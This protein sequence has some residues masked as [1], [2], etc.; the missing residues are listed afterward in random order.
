MYCVRLKGWW[1]TCS[2]RRR[3]RRRRRSRRRPCLRPLALL[4]S[5]L[6]VVF[7]GNAPSLALAARRRP[8]RRGD[9]LPFVPRGATVAGTRGDTLPRSSRRGVRGSSRA[10]RHGDS[11]ARRGRSVPGSRARRASGRRPRRP[12][13]GRH[14]AIAASGDSGDDA[15]AANG[16]RA[17]VVEVRRGYVRYQQIVSRSKNKDHTFKKSILYWHLLTYSTV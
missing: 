9:A 8:G 5:G 3:R 6:I 14:T 15:A 12:V 13:T 2:S 10:A 7:G 16:A 17:G 1:G 4:S 11:T